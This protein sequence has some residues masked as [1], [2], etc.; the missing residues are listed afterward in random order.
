MLSNLNDRGFT[1][2]GTNSSRFYNNI[3][4]IQWK[5]VWKVN[6]IGVSFTFSMVSYALLSDFKIHIPNQILWLNH[7]QFKHAHTML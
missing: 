3:L 4:C 7:G 5:N 6:Q 1:Y 2:C